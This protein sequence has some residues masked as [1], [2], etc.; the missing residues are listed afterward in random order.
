MGI[1]SVMMAGFGGCFDPQSRRASNV[2]DEIAD[3]Y[4]DEPWVEAIGIGTRD[5]EWVV[6]VT[7]S[8]QEEVPNDFPKEKARVRI[9]IEEGEIVPVG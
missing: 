5:G 2:K 4:L 1:A 9:V 7:V 3:H 8:D 6:I